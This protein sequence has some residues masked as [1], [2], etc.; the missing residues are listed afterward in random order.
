M[1]QQKPF[2]GILSDV[3]VAYKCISQALHAKFVVKTETGNGCD[4]GGDSGN[5]GGCSIPPYVKLALELS[6]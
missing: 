6:R 1:N 3:T 5:D 4:G 2:A